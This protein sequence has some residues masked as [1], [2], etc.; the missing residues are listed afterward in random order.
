MQ[1]MA[2]CRSDAACKRML[3]EMNIDLDKFVDILVS[4]ESVASDIAAF[5]AQIRAPS[6]V[7]TNVQ[8]LQSKMSGKKWQSG[9]KKGEKGGKRGAGR[10]D[11]TC[12]SCG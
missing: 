11:V 9:G 6:A 7:S 10:Q 8:P 5:G 1:I 4:E 12:Y 2:G 3:L